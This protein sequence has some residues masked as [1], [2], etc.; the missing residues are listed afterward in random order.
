MKKAA[1]LFLVLSFSFLTGLYA[2][3]NIDGVFN[4]SDYSL[5]ST[6]LNANNGFAPD[7]EFTAIYYSRSDE[8]HYLGFEC[9]VQN[10]PNQ[11][12][13]KPDG[14]GIFLNFS[15][16]EGKEA[17]QTLGI[18][19]TIDYHFLNGGIELFPEYTLEFKADFEADYILAVYSNST[20]N[21][22][23]VDAVTHVANH[24]LQIQ[25]IGTT[26]QSGTPVSGPTANGVFSAGSIE[27]AFIPSSGD[28][29]RMG[30]E[31]K[32]PFSEVNA[33][34]MDWFQ[35]FGTIVASTAYF[36]DQTIPGNVLTGNSGWSPDYFNN[37]TS[38]DCGC[39][40]PNTS[41]GTGPFHSPQI[42]PL[43]LSIPN[44]GEVWVF[45]T[46]QEIRW[47]SDDIENIKIEYT[48]DGD[49]IWNTI[50][51]S[52]SANLGNF[53][54]LTPNIQSQ[55]CRIRISDV[56][57]STLFDVSDNY[58]TIGRPTT[59]IEPNNSPSQANLML[60]GD[61]LDASINP[62]G[63]VDYF[64][65]P[66]DANDTLQVSVYDINNSSL[67]GRLE[68]SDEYGYILNYLYFYSWNNDNRLF[69]I[70]PYSGNYF[71][72][73]SYAY[74]NKEK[75]SFNSKR[76]SI[77]LNKRKKLNKVISETGDYRICLREFIP[78]APKISFTYNFN[79]YYNSTVAYMEFDP[80][81]LT[82]SVKIEYGL[83]PNYGNTAV[84]PGT[85]SGLGLNGATARLT[86]LKAG[87]EYFF[88]SVAENDSGISYSEQYIFFTPDRP[89]FW[90]IKSIDSLNNYFW[91]TDVSF[92][93]ENAGYILNQGN[94][95][96]FKTTDGGDSWIE[97]YPGYY[98]TKIF[99]FDS[100][101]VFALSDYGII[102]TTNGGLSWDYKD[103][104]AGYS[105]LDLFFT[106]VNTGYVVGYNG[107]IFKTT[108]S[109]NSWAA[110]TSGTYYSLYAVYF[111]DA[112]N[113][114]A[115]GDFGI[116]L[117]TSNGGSSWTS[118]I[119]GTTNLL[120]HI[121][122]VD[123]ENGYAVDQW[124]GIV[125]TTNG[126]TSWNI[127]FTGLYGIRDISFINKNDGVLIGG[128]QGEILLTI[129]AGINWVP[130]KSGTLNYLNAVS[131]AGNNWIVVGDY[132]TILKSTYNI[133]SVEKMD[134]Y[135]TTYKLIQN[136]PNPFNPSTK[137]SWQLPVGSH[138]KLIV[139]DMLGNEV[140]IL[141]DEEKPA[142]T[143]E[144]EFE[145][146][147]LSSGVYFYRIQSGNFIQTRKM[148][149]VK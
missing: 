139:Y 21:E 60:I 90:A 79:T 42:G 100:V 55:Y 132:G 2:Q 120:N 13:P 53:Y 8:N 12:N 18:N 126:G 41:I 36:S 136:Y 48:S 32:I 25:N 85:F 97:N 128:Y 24:P 47:F 125:K 127:Y 91:F 135:P 30:F 17:G 112:N 35:L 67:D 95:L 51:E 106:D 77:E 28:G 137:I 129:D 20:P 109:G 88:R 49:T 83:T 9:R 108:N 130:Q 52:I 117:K 96:I 123:S 6:P 71:I 66:A 23:I 7:C 40:N 121:F 29:S 26:N 58:F 10:V 124:N 111:A 144:V 38:M 107:I 37:L 119:S 102:K 31:I 92:A 4:E 81:G 63:D 44:G 98:L 45:N 1:I 122:F 142:G 56:E 116:I 15:S 3:I 65:F 64:K 5:I 146:L 80:M 22:I 110:L 149:L 145:A 72:R 140:A 118:Q 113:G 138:T 93:N 19:S 87:S 147:H 94:N 59:E 34:Q 27:F 82:T 89:E 70:V 134:E 11:Y 78:S 101:N 54:W 115:S 16:Q 86:D 39:P 73:V 14:L 103:V 84:I 99:C 57:D 114:W 76:D 61:S 33:T 69:F 105:L 141:V 68:I 50:V 74:S 143:Y 148:I 43:S 133:V 131:K 104:G 46:I 75:I 62:F